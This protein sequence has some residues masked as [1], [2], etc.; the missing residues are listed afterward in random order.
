MLE[1]WLR[2]SACIYGWKLLLPALKSPMCDASFFTAF[3]F[4]KSHFW[5]ATCDFF[6]TFEF[7]GGIN[8]KTKSM[9]T[10]LAYLKNKFLWG[11]LDALTP[12]SQTMRSMQW[13]ESNAVIY[14]ASCRS[15]ACCNSSKEPNLSSNSEERPWPNDRP[16]LVVVLVNMVTRGTAST[17]KTKGTTR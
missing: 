2:H 5:S 13:S 9:P 8:Y 4:R 12:N 17:N 14:L 1:K 10:F 16:L 3:Y 7:L 6:D 11:M 15:M